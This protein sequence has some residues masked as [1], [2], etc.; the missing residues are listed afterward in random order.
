MVPNF[1][2]E[3][4]RKNFVPILSKIIISQTAPAENLQSLS[5]LLS[6]ALESRISNEASVRNSLNKLNT[7][8]NKILSTSPDGSNRAIELTEDPSVH[9][10]DAMETDV[11]DAGDLTMLTR[12]DHEG[13]VFPDSNEEEEDDDSVDVTTGLAKKFVQDNS[14]VESLLDDDEDADEGTDETIST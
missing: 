6:E 3:E 1:K 11:V 2:S 7:S 9:I 8:V 5:A 12:P 10:P 14:L 4:E 13:T